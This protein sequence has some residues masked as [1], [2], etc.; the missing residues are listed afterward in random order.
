MNYL[1]SRPELT[2]LKLKEVLE[3]DKELLKLYNVQI[4]KSHFI[5]RG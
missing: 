3:S 4:T 5:Y 1:K 2:T